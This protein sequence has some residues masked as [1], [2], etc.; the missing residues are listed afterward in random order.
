[1][2]FYRKFLIILSIIFLFIL[3]I[4]YFIP[5]ET[6]TNTKYKSYLEINKEYNWKYIYFDP[7]G[8]IEGCIGLIT[9]T[10]PNEPFFEGKKLFF[11][12]KGKV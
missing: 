12:K 9:E 6:I 1:M 2:V 8:G 4:N 11:E 5:K 10:I 3:R 7:L